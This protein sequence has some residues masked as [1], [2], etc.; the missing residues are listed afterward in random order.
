MKYL[1][2]GG[3]GFIGSHVARLLV[4]KGHMVCVVDNLLK[5]YRENLDGLRVDFVQGDVR[6]R[7]LMRKVTA[8]VDGVFHLAA[9][10]SNVKSVSDPEED[11]T[12]NA[13]GTVTVLHAATENNV[14][15]FVYSSSAAIFGELKANPIDEDHPLEP[16]SPYGVSKLAG[17]RYCLAFA[18]LFPMTIVA[19]R[20]F[21]VYGTHQRYD[22]Y[23]NVIPI[24][25]NRLFNGQSLTIYG[26]GEQTRDFVHVR[27]IAQAN[28]LAATRATESAVYNVGTGH[29][30]TVNDLAHR[31]QRASGIRT[32]LRFAPRRKGE[33]THCRAEIGKIQQ[34]LGYA[35]SVDMDTALVEYFDWFKRDQTR[36]P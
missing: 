13:L 14:Q 23:G 24:F 33:V 26:N 7:A 30:I 2:T 11:C 19:L 21:N 10:I 35:P 27:D 28:Y 6:D 16:M 29:S 17:E 9:L 32:D 1:V 3:A 8:G 5:G 12:V 36:S 15:R 18:K 25:A 34:A 4:D 31:V 20:Y 22:E